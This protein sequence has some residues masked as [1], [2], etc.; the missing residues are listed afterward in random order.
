[1]SISISIFPDLV[2]Q[3]DTVTVKETASLTPERVDRYIISPKG[4]YYFIST[5]KVGEWSF[6]IDEY[7]EIFGEPWIYRIMDVAHESEYSPASST[8]FFIYKG[9]KEIS[10]CL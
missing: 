4:S 5:G 6:N 9:A 8:E 7:P 3:G 2:Y 10:R 1:M